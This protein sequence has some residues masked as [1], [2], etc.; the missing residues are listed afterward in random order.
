MSLAALMLVAL[1]LF[2]VLC[3]SKARKWTRTIPVAGGGAVVRKGSTAALEE[4]DSIA[5]S[6]RKV[7]VISR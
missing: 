5:E 1:A 6:Q 2:L 3:D 4:R 7:S